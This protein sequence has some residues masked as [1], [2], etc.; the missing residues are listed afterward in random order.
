[1]LDN[2]EITSLLIAKKYKE[3]TEF[4]NE[5]EIYE[6]TPHP[7]RYTNLKYLLK[8]LSFPISITC[9]LIKVVSQGILTV[10]FF[11]LPE[12]ILNKINNGISK[13][14]LHGLPEENDDDQTIPKIVEQ[15]LKKYEEQPEKYEEQ[16]ELIVQPETSLI[17]KVAAK[18]SEYIPGFSKFTNFWDNGGINY[19]DE[20]QKKQPIIDSIYK[21]I[22]SAAYNA[23]KKGEKLE[24]KDVQELFP[25]VNFEKTAETVTVEN[26]K[27][28]II[29]EDNNVSLACTHHPID[30]NPANIEV[31][32]NSNPLINGIQQKMAEIYLE[33]CLAEYFIYHNNTFN[34]STEQSLSLE[35]HNYSI[36]GYNTEAIDCC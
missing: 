3:V 18:V 10:N 36:I 31:T 17:K 8:T 30:Q 5:S 4:Q 20:I 9:N 23:G 11:N 27:E 15:I 33:H 19:S 24:I 2:Q 21:E 1:M 22:I 29:E 7:L 34:D 6:F 26:V 32:T 25:Q 12:I 35:P 16:P 28:V 14:I 13:K